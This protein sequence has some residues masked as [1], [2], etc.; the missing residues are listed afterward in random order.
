MKRREKPELSCSVISGDPL[1]IRED[2]ILLEKGGINSF[3]F[4]VMDGVF[5]PRLGL[6]PEYLRMLKDLTSLPIEIHLMLED[7]EPYIEHFTKFGEV[8]LIPHIV[9]LRHAIRT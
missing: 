2:V 1:S 6:Y 5:V 8:K 3:H 7:P 4:D 9:S